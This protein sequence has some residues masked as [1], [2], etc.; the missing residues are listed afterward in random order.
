MALVGTRSHILHSPRSI[1][2]DRVSQL[3]VF[4]AAITLISST[5]AVTPL[6]V[7]GADYVNSVNGNRFQIIGVAYQP[8]GS[9]GYNPGSDPL[10]DTPSCLRDATL[11]QQLGVN[12][13]R[14]YNVD[15]DVNHDQC[16]SIFNAAGIYMIIDVNSPLPNQSLNRGAPW[17]SYNSAYINR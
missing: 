4:L 1:C 16:V 5:F 13:I 6:D 15:P 17:E 8:G 11:M 10:S 14:V 3:N 9:S 7:K 12:A 2:T